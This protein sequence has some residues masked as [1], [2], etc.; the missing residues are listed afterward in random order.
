MERYDIMVGM[1]GARTDGVINRE[2]HFTDVI[3]LD[4]TEYC[5]KHQAI[6]TECNWVG[7]IFDNYFDAVDEANE[8]EGKERNWW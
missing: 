1:A 6:C 8:H 2:E 5:D 4:D 3:T 7:Q